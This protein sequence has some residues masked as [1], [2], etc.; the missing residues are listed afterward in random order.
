MNDP[1]DDAGFFQ[2]ASGMY[3]SMRLMSFLSLL[4][5]ILFGVLTCLGKGGDSG[6]LLTLSFLSAGFG[7]KI[8][9]KPLEKN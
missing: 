8:V 4:A 2:E 6:V 1:Q 3:S 7:G 5:A 9:Q